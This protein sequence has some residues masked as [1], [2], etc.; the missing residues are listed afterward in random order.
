MTKLVTTIATAVEG[1][2]WIKAFSLYSMG[3]ACYVIGT[4][5]FLAIQ[6]YPHCE[7]NDHAGRP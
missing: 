5:Q 1:P 3:L 4:V 7:T 6:A 2:E